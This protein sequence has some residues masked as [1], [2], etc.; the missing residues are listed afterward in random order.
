VGDLVGPVQ[1]DFGWHIIKVTGVTP[2]RIRPFEEVKESI[3]AELKRA[4]AAQQF[5]TAADQFQNLVYENAD[6]LEPVAK[7]LD[8]KVLTAP[9]AT[10]AQAL[11]VAMGNQKFVEALFSKDS[12]EA[13][14]NT[15]AMEIGPNTLIAGRIVEY[16]P[17]TPRPFDEVKDDIKLQ[18]ARLAA[19][20][21]AQK[22][23][24]EKLALLEQGKSEKEAGVT[25]G[26]VQTVGRNQAQPGFTPDA[27]KEV[28]HAETAKLPSYAGAT[29]EKGGYSIYKI[30]KV[31]EPA[32]P[33]DAKLNAATSRVREELG[34]EL[35]N[36]Y[37]AAL[38]SDA[39]VKI[40][41]ANIEKK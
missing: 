12:I 15:E 3:E 19:S 27:L 30:T 31:I 25:F 36:A 13:K 20:E 40:N 22:A 33:D 14:R 11:G 32:A 7:K 23:G 18:L 17:A 4:K 39:D 9:L 8:L 41:Q 5:A 37:L 16:K 35:M 34:R 28:F 26:K 29:N 6:S 21:L 2:A 24:K 10:R 38:K 1:T